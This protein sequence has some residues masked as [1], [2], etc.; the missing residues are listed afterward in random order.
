MQKKKSGRKKA[1]KESEKPRRVGEVPVGKK[2][3]EGSGSAAPRASRRQ[4]NKAPTFRST[5]QRFFHDLSALSRVSDVTTEAAAAASDKA[6]DRITDVI[7]AMKN[8]LQEA[9]KKSE[10][11]SSDEM[12]KY[13]REVGALTGVIG[14]SWL[15][16]RGFVLVLVSQYDAFL[17]RLLKCAYIS[18]PEI[19]KSV[20][21]TL[22][23]SEL[24]Q[25]EN[26]N[27][28]RDA[29]IDKEVETVLRDSHADQFAWMEKRFGIELRKGLMSWPV[30]IELTERRNLFAHGDATVSKQYLTNCKAHGVAIA[31]NIKPGSTL[32]ASHEYFNSSLE[33]VLEIGIKLYQ[34]L[35]RKLLPAESKEA[36]ADLTLLSLDLIADGRYAVAAEI[37]RTFLKEIPRCFLTDDSRRVAVINLAQSYKWMGKNSE[38]LAVIDE[39]DWSA[40]M[41]KFQLGV[42]V[43]RDDFDQ[44]ASIVRSLGSESDQVTRNNYHEWPLFK[45]FR[46]SKQFLQAFEEVF[47]QPFDVPSKAEVE[48]MAKMIPTEVTPS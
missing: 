30:F 48:Q 4:P 15:V 3:A 44:A 34:V 46:K 25:F 2:R 19:L 13:V 12:S 37:L 10:Y 47:K 22:E 32:D 36:D 29:I 1:G 38:C 5:G 14:G 20:S 21:R 40:C 7:K 26:L 8:V 17:G 33:C 28:V 45:E 23:V 18:K 27:D 9:K 43:L 41:R 24:L 35:W 11:I 16:G 42:A 31:N 39:Q 6:V